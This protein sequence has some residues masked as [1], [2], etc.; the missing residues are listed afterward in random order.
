MCEN[1]RLNCRF[2][3]VFTLCVSLGVF[4][5]LVFFP[6]ML[7]LLGTSRER[8]ANKVKD[9]VKVDKVNGEKE[10]N[11]TMNPAFVIDDELASRETSEC[12]R[13]VA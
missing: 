10:P 7:G 9:E 2:S 11:G 4:H 5:G 12:E 1:R 3:R 8:E 6:V 13:E